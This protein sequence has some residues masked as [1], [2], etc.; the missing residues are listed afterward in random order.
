MADAATGEAVTAVRALW[1]FVKFLGGLLVSVHVY[2]LVLFFAPV[3]G[4]ANLAG[5]A[6]QGPQLYYSWTPI[7]EISPHL[8][9]AVIAA[10][11]THFRQN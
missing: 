3:P 1:L 11:D 8:V 10:E 5:R 6:L 7:A 2:A 9:R 4:T